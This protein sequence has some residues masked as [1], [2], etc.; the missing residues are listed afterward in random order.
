MIKRALQYLLALMLATIILVIVVLIAPYL[1][2]QSAWGIVTG[3]GAK[4]EE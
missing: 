3:E 1:A 2:L 4:V